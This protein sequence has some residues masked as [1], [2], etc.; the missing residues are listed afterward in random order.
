MTSYIETVENAIHA[1]RN[2]QMIILTD[3]PERENEGDLIFP[4]EII[5]PDIVNFMIRHCSGIICLSLTAEQL[6][7]IGITYMVSPDQNT[8][9]RGTPFTVSIEAK[10]GVTTGVSASDRAKTILAAVKPDGSEK[11]LVKPGHIFPLHANSGGVLARQGHTEGAMDIV[12]LA[13]FTPA[14]VLCEVMNPDG[15]MAKGKDL[16]EF[17]RHHQLSMVSID[18]IIAYRRNKEDLIQEEVTTQLPLEKYGLFNLSVVKEKFNQ[19]EHIILSSE[20]PWVTRPLTRVH[21]A[22]I[23]GDMFGSKRCDCNKQLDYSLK[24]ISEQGGVLI[25]LN[26]E[27]R[28]IGLFNKI[29]TY[30]LQDNGL[31]TVEANASLGLPIDSRDY[32]LAA[33]ILKNRNINSIRLL[34]NNPNK[35]NGLK[36]YGIDVAEIEQI[37]VFLNKYNEHYLLTKKEKL[38]HLINFNQ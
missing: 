1:L 27:G 23:T 5:T 22:C 16:L 14:A 35:T 4:A 6:Q 12:K 15:S 17:A 32:Y 3:N 30:M 8:S 33:N 11:D 25:Y 38:N 20:K 37:P 34:T 29:Q 21:S 18:D 9:S 13:G 2:R 31:D 19:H 7:K 26:Q 24:K 10:E 36:K 28:G